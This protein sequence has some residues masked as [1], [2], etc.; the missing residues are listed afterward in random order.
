ME[1]LGAEHLPQLIEVLI[2]TGQVASKALLQRLLLNS[3]TPSESYHGCNC[4]DIAKQS[5]H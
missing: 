3:S 5:V 2:S 4:V 1:S